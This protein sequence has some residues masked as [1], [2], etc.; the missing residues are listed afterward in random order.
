MQLFSN[1]QHTAASSTNAEPHENCRL[2]ISSKDKI[3]LDM[4]MSAI[5]AQSLTDTASLNI[6]SA[7]TAVAAISKLLRSEAFAAVV[8]PSP[9]IRH[10][11]A[12]ISSKIIPST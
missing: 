3:I 4:V 1:P 2:D 10:I 11:G 5:P 9:Y 7:M 8:A 6:T 12:A